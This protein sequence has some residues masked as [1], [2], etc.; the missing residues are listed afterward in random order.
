MR[1]PLLR[2]QSLICRLWGSADREVWL[3]ILRFVSGSFFDAPVFSI[4]WPALFPVCFRFVFSAFPLFSTN[5]VASFPLCFRFVFWPDHLFS[6][7]SP[8]CFLKKEFF[9]LFLRLLKP[10]SNVVPWHSAIFAI[11]AIVP[12]LGLSWRPRIRCICTAT[13]AVY[14]CGLSFPATEEP[15]RLAGRYMYKQMPATQKARRC[16]GAIAGAPPTGRG[17]QPPTN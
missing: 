13:F 7:T 15:P 12:F 6:I 1:Q 4:T 17:N 2:L 8:V 3:Q 16:R 14:R 11:L 5:S 9:F 10:Y